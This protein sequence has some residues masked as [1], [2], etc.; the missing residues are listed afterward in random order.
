VATHDK[1][2]VDSMRKR[3]VALDAG[4]IVRDQARGVYGH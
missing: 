3:V 2:M 1:E 4:R